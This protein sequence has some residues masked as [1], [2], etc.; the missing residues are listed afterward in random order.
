MG[1]EPSFSAAS[2]PAK[3]VAEPV[4]QPH[5]P[6]TSVPSRGSAQGDILFLQRHAGNAAVVRMLQRSVQDEGEPGRRPS[7]DV[8][9]SGPGVVLLQ[10]LLGANQTGAFDT[11]TRHAVDRFQR[12]QGGSPVAWA[13]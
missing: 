8:S 7:L 6:S 11:Q 9:N 2:E 3:A 10:R 12:Q 5:A 13:R 4:T 1:D